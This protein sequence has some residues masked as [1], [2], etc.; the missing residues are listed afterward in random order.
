M[1]LPLST[2]SIRG[3]SA[4]LHHD[5]HKKNVFPEPVGDWISTPLHGTA[6]VYKAFTHLITACHTACKTLS[7]FDNRTHTQVK[8]KP[9]DLIGS[10]GV[11]SSH[12]SPWSHRTTSAQLAVSH[13][14]V[15]RLRLQS[16]PLSEPLMRVR[17]TCTSPN[18]SHLFKHPEADQN[19]VFCVYYQW[20]VC[21]SRGDV[22]SIKSGKSSD[23]T[24]D[25]RLSCHRLG[26]D[27]EV[28]KMTSA[29]SAL[30]LLLWRWTPRTLNV[31]QCKQSV[32]LCSLEL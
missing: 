7:L 6:I 30:V 31:P 27:W 2:P 13:S 26:P 10:G 9:A 22:V 23:A 1:I 21:Q 15:R 25:S 29:T 32:C 4:K 3:D 11:S 17:E 12:L 5:S 24:A 8:R 16:T 19:D 14:P 20:K 28:E 18:A